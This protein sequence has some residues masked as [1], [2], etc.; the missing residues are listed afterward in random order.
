MR[1]VGRLVVADEVVMKNE[2]ADLKMVVLGWF[3]DLE[4]AD[5]T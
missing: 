5:R 2:V 4:V 1:E 3:S